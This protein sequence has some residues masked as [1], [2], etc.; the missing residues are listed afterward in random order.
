MKE[1]PTGHVHMMIAIPPKYAAPQV[2]GFIKGRSVIHFALVYF[3]RKRNFV[4]QHLVAQRVLC[5]DSRSRYGG[6][7]VRAG[8]HQEVGARG[9]AI[10]PTRPTK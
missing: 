6:G 5:V 7:A 10:E 8:L 2:I 3:E 4:A 9:R 1:V